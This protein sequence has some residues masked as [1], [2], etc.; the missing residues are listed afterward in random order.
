MN[1][2]VKALWV[3]DLRSGKHKQAQGVL[4]RD[5]A[6]CCLG[7]LCDL[8]QQAHPN[9]VWSNHPNCYSEYQDCSTVLPIDVIAW[10]GLNGGNPRASM[11]TLSA[12]NDSGKTFAQIADV[13]EREF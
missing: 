6:F 11:S 5:D 8:H 7:R 13:I 3:A 1:P 2:E 10:S 12:L 9:I 4:R